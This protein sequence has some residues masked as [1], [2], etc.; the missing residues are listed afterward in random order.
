MTEKNI[1]DYELF[2]SLNISDFSLFFMQKLQPPEKG[3]PPPSF[4]ANLLYKI[5]SSPPF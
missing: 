2:L 4:A 1:F 5:L 3:H